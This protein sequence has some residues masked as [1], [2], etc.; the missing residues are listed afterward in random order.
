MAK[1]PGRLLGPVVMA[2]LA[3]ML[4]VGPGFLEPPPALVGESRVEWDELQAHLGEAAGGQILEELALGLALKREVQSRGVTVASNAIEHE[5]EMLT[6][7][8]ASAANL[9]AGDGEALLERVRVNRGLGPVRFAA[10]LER[11]A[12]LRALVR[13]DGAGLEISEDDLRQAWELKHGARVLARMILVRSEQSARSAADRVAA[14]ESF[15]EVAAQVSIDPSSSR[16]GVLD[17]FSPSDPNYPAAIR[18]VVGELEVGKVSPPVA[19]SWGTNQG[20]ALVRVEQRIAPAADAPSLDSAKEQL[21]AE[22]RLVRER[23]A[24]D[25]LAKRLIADASVTVF[26]RSLGW[27]W[28][29]R[30]GP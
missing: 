3:V 17:P 13:A 20:Y 30:S 22:V 18:K 15:A 7:A 1:R 28:E 2:S 29:K 9:P 8:L 23:A 21:R 11:N 5:R 19:V 25:R 14:G 6:T 24:M 16:G 12:Q 26:D 27:S 10:L 4:G